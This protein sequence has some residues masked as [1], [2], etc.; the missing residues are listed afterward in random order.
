[1]KYPGSTKVLLFA[2]ALCTLGAIP[3]QWIIFKK[4]APFSVHLYGFHH[5]FAYETPPDKV[6]IKVRSEHK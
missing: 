1:M 6:M 3:L 4:S 2:Q 5:A